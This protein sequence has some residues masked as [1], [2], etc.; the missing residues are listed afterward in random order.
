[1]RWHQ[2]AESHFSPHPNSRSSTSLPGSFARARSDIWTGSKNET[3]E[4]DILVTPNCQHFENSWISA[5]WVRTIPFWGWIEHSKSGKARA[6]PP[7]WYRRH[8]HPCNRL[9]MRTQTPGLSGKATNEDR[10]DTIECND[11]A[12]EMMVGCAGMRRY[13]YEPTLQGMSMSI[14]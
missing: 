11:C 9:P 14:T 13:P 7:Q 1:M 2:V 10:R 4:K 8:S 5:R 6:I 3:K 12:A